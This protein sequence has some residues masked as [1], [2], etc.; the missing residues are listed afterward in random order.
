MSIVFQYYHPREEV[1]RMLRG[2]LL[3]WNLSFYAVVVCPS[4]SVCMSVC[5]SVTVTI[6][7]RMQGHRLRIRD[8][9]T[10]IWLLLAPV[11]AIKFV[12]G[13]LLL[14]GLLFKILM[15]TLGEFSVYFVIG[16]LLIF[17]YFWATN[18]SNFIIKISWHF[19]MC[20]FPKFI[21]F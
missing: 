20:E 9:K 18:L 21:T 13:D 2:K 3:P 17:A 12:F 16:W 6:A 19:K 4:V 1:T 7:I 10:Q 15:A 14:F 11:G 5:T 8:E